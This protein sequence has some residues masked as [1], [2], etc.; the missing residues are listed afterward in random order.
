V[1]TLGNIVRKKLH[2][3]PGTMC[4]EQLWIELL[5]YLQDSFELVYLSIPRGKNFDELADYYYDLFD[6][7]SVNLIGFSLGGY[8]A[9]YFSTVYP[10]CVEKLFVI[11]NSPTSLPIEEL[12]QRSDILR[13]VGIHGYQGISRKKAAGLLDSKKQTD[14]LIALILAM[15]SECG[16]K[17]FISQYQYTS[18]RTDLTQ[19]ISQLPFNIHVYYSE[20]DPLVNAK[21]LNDLTQL[22]PKLTLSS[23]SG[24][25]HMLPLEKPSELAGYITEW[26]ALSQT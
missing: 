20:N 25:G 9:S 21:W 13:Y 10:E 12:N 23:T 19:T 11:S 26:A 24:S 3:I 8:I 18:K 22:A 17:E 16:E 4:N 7:D 1:I 15:D 5:P 2:L 6:G 14:S